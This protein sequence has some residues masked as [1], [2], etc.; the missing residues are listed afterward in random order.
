MGFVEIFM[1]LVWGLC[2]LW[3]AFSAF[4]EKGEGFLSG[5]HLVA[6]VAIVAVAF[7]AY[8]SFVFRRTTK[9]RAEI[10]ETK[11]LLEMT[12]RGD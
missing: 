5:H 10:S 12:S 3:A 2:L 11:K 7:V 1:V 9:L 4:V 8:F 6:L